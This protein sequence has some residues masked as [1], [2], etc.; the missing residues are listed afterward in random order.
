M[1]SWEDY[2]EGET[3]SFGRIKVTADTIKRF[4]VAYDP[5]PFHL[6]DG[7]ARATPLRGLAA[8]GWHTCA[9]LMRQ[10]EQQV[11]S[12]SGY[13]GSPGIDDIRWL[14]PV[15]PGD[16]L[17]GKIIWLSKCPCSRRSD[18]G[19]WSIAIEAI[20]QSGD[21]VL[22]LNGHVLLARRGAAVADVPR[23]SSCCAAR[24]ARPPR[25]RRRPGDHLIRYFEDV[26]QGDEIALGSYDFTTDAIHSY[27]HNIGTPTGDREPPA[28]AVGEGS[29]RRVNGWHIIAAWMRRIVDYYQAEA[30]WLAG[31]GRPVPLLG[32]AVGARSLYWLK[33]V[34][35][36]DRITFSSW[37][38]HKLQAGTSSEWGLLVAGAE[39]VD[40]KGEVV[41]S[42]Y[43]QFLLQRQPQR[44][45]GRG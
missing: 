17:E 28:H 9:L 42:L 3:G 25:A 27:S 45:G 19:R 21:L 32:P 10:V 44:D 7:A 13:L 24:L 39:G 41:V 35:S 26:Q 8:S 12:M 43:P 34:H 15:R 30:D 20:N 1:R 40:Q 38:E 33:P 37:V 18:V 31:K 11:L 29:C 6:D 22:R 4:A 23:S 5:Q 36:G 14:K 2:S 16:I